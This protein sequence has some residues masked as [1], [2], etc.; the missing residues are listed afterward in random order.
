MLER[1][2]KNGRPCANEFY[3]KAFFVGQDERPKKQRGKSEAKKEIAFL[4]L[5]LA[6]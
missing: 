2:A 3:N 4:L 5:A 6:T 1:T